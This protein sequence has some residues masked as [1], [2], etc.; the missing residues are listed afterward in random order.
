MRLVICDDHRLLTEALASLL[1]AHGHVVEGV[2][3]SADEVLRV[4][5][6]SD[7]DVCLLDINLAGGNEG[8]AVAGQLLERHPRTKV[9]ILSAISEATVVA[10][11]IDAGVVGFVRKDQSASRIASALERVSAGDMAID[12]D[13]LR[14]AVRTTPS[15]PRS[16]T[17]RMLAFLTAK[18]REVLL[19]LVGGAS[20]AEIAHSLGIAPSTARTHVQN[21]LVKLGAHSRLQATAMVANAGVL[22]EL[23]AGKDDRRRTGR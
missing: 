8:L 15:G 4:V 10:A 20:T 18:E 6:E 1:S 23:R 13:L 16:E 9:V 14:A 17:S 7:P 3:Y 12:G 21:V 19:L 5:A 11:A 2:A 22:D